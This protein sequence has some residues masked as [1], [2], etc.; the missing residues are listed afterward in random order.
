MPAHQPT[1]PAA[2]GQSR[3]SGVGDDPSRR[4][5]P[6]GLRFAIELA[7]QQAWLGAG[8]S[9]RGIDP[10]ALHGREVDHEAF[11]AYGRAG[12]VVAPPRTATTRLRSRAN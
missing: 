5:Q 10:H 4:R 3:N 11:V 1:D 7:P 6:E 8:G 9:R 12:D 2:K